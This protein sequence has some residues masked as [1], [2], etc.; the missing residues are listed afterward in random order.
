MNLKRLGLVLSASAGVALLYAACGDGGGGGDGSCT[1]NA[2]CKTNEICHPVEKVCVQTCNIGA[3]CPDTAKDCRP[4]GSAP[5]GDAGTADG[6]SGQKICHCSLTNLC[7]SGNVGGSL[8]CN[9]ETRICVVKCSND[10]ACGAGRKCDTATGQ[11]KAS[12]GTC[13]PACGADKVCDNGQCVDKCKVGSCAAGKTCNTSTGLCE[14]AKSC[15]ASNPQPDACSNGQ[16]CSTGTC[17]DVSTGTCPNIT[18]H[19]ASWTPTANGQIIYEVSKVFFR[20][21]QRT[22]GMFFCGGSTDADP[23]ERVKV[24]IKAYAGPNASAFPA[25]E[26]GLPAIL[27]YVKADGSEGPVTGTVQAYTVSNNNKNVEFD[28]NYCLPKGTTSFSGAWHFV[29]G[30]EVCAQIAHD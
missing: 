27:H 11:C 5:G 26:A 10:A 24:H 21:D 29:N 23:M 6:G 18:A 7:N 22:G 14:T 1:S 15:N 3:D 13:N 16:F 28:L 2:N 9:D 8:V 20:P 12:G 25:T 17:K 4:L 19:G 30:N